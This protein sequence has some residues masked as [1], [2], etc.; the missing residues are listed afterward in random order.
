MDLDTNPCICICS[1]TFH[2][3]HND[4]LRHNTSCPNIRS[5]NPNP[6]NN[7]DKWLCMQWTQRFVFRDAQRAVFNSG[8]RIDGPDNV[9]TRYERM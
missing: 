1:A 8:Q 6:D 2:N 3:F 5:H 7:E 4:I 9:E